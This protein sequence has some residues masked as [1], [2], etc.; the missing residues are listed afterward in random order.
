MDIVARGTVIFGLV[1]DLVADNC[2][3]VR[4]ML[5]QL[6]DDPFAVK[7]VGR[8]SDVHDLPGTIGTAALSGFCEHFRVH[9]F[10]PGG[11]RI[12][13][14]TDNDVDTGFI[15]CIQYPVNV[16][17]IKITGTGFHC[18]PGR[19]CDTDDVNSRFLHHTDIFV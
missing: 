15:H 8:R 17:I 2:R 4:D 10:Q 11:D 14:R 5:H 6:A 16:G 9:L 13:W 19:F 18:R 7:Q 3:M 1:V 12:G